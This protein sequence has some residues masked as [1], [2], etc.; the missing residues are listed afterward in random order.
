MVSI[1]DI[2]KYCGVSA[3]TVSR[4]LNNSSDIKVTTREKILKACEELKYKPNSAAKSLITKKTNM[5]GLIIPDIANQYYANISKGVGEYIEKHGYGLI[6][7]NSNRKKI[8]EVKYLDFLSE[9]RVDGMIILPVKPMKKDYEDILNQIPM[10]MADNFAEGLE[11]NF[12][13]IDNYTGAFKI[14]THMISKG[15]KK[16][17]VILGDERS[18]ASGERLEGY[19]RAL[20]D[21]KIRYNDEIII[22]SNSTFEDGF[23]I[24]ST[25]I[26]KGVDS[27]FAINDTVAMGVM[28]YCYENKIKLPMDLGIAGYDN[29]EQSAMLSIPLTTV[30]QN[31]KEVGTIAAK[32]LINS[33]DNKSKKV[34]KVILEPILVVRKS[35]RE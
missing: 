13:G 6:L 32:M 26:K 25:L 1:K 10:V 9:G 21:N 2:A 20:L 11:V 3:M 15:Y 33:I 4:A 12:V 22:N 30:D 29:I 27:I 5:I 19:K 17:G 18:T 7:C 28:K 24:A 16:I 8:N 31:S 14:I 23:N 34:E 35:C